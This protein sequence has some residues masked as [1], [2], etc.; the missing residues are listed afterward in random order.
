MV[1]L[2]R[3][4]RDPYGG[5][6]IDP[7]T[8]DSAACVKTI[9][10]F[11]HAHSQALAQNGAL[12]GVLGRAQD[13]LVLAQAKFQSSLTHF[14]QTQGIAALAAALFRAAYTNLTST[15]GSS[16]RL[17][18]LAQELPDLLCPPDFSSLVAPAPTAVTE[19][20]EIEELP[21]SVTMEPL[22]EA[23]SPALCRRELILAAGAY[24]DCRARI[25]ALR[26]RIWQIKSE[27]A[28][29]SLKT[30]RVEEATATLAA[31]GQTYRTAHATVNAEAVRLRTPPARLTDAPL[32]TCS[33]HK[34]IVLL[35]AALVA[36]LI[37]RKPFQPP[38]RV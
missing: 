12:Q 24:E 32:Q 38:D 33:W 15:L 37:L 30:N 19:I 20:E 11:R 2:A 10:R 13:A 8:L 36:W 23:D 26:Q 7:E 18:A 31:H 27:T 6:S 5:S 3:S 34:R 22:L 14:R 17:D 4:Y 16:S 1:S 35:I 28:L 25:D 21:P 29:Y 9:A